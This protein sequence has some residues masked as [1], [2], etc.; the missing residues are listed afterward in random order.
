MS[1]VVMVDSGASL[2]LYILK[3]K[4]I[5]VIPLSIE[6]N[7]NEIME[8]NDI[9]YEQKAN[10]MPIIHKPEISKIKK[11][12]DRYLESGMDVLFIT[13]SS[14]LSNEY[15]DLVETFKNYDSST[16]SI[17]DSLNVGSGESLLVLKALELMDSGYGLKYITNYINK[18]KYDIKSTYV[19]ENFPFLYAQNVCEDFECKYI[20]FKDRYP[21]LNLSDGDAKVSFNSAKLDAAYQ[22]FEDNIF[23]SLSNNEINEVIISYVSNKEAI[24]KIKHSLKR[25]CKNITITLIKSNLFLKLCLGDNGVCYSIINK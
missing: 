7:E 14:K 15:Y 5:Q 20:N 9:N 4:D 6:L 10:L 2:P 17:I 11:D 22:I 23:D 12:I 1:I 18:I 8:L 21:I 25:R 13:I 16:I 3:R 24:E 19:I